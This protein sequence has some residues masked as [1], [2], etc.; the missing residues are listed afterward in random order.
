MSI[1]TRV[2]P[3]AVIA[4][5]GLMLV[6]SANAGGRRHGCCCSDGSTATAAT[7]QPATPPAVAQ[8]PGETRTE[9]RFSYEPSTEAAPT[10]RSRS[11]SDG[12][13]YGLD[14]TQAAK[15]YRSGR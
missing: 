12:G 13:A 4:L 15:A 5:A 2:V 14:Y 3:V 7:T 9:R 10:Y 8:K 11:N 6:D 1:L